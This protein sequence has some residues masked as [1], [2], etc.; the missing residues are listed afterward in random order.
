MKRFK[1]SLTKNPVF[2]SVTGLLNKTWNGT[3]VSGRAATEDQLKAAI[4]NLPADVNTITT[5]AG[6]GGIDVTDAGTGGNHDYTVKPGSQLTVGSTEQGSTDNPIF[7]DGQTGYLDGLSNTTWDTTPPQGGGP[8][9]N[10]I[11]GRA[12][13]EDQLAAAIASLPADVNT[14]TT[15]TAGNSIKV[16]DNGT[17]GNH[18]Y[19][20]DNTIKYKNVENHGFS[21]YDVGGEK[22]VMNVQAPVE[23]VKMEDGG[24]D[25]DSSA[26]F[27]TYT[28]KYTVHVPELEAGN[29]V[30]FTN[31][32]DG[33][34]GTSAA[35][36]TKIVV[37][38]NNTVTTLA[39][40]SGSSNVTVTDNGTDGNHA[41]VI[42]VDEGE[43]VEVVSD[44]TNIVVTVETV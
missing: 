3:P 28:G 24:T 7:I 19:T 39:A 1:L 25:Y 31:T 36:I 6:A 13:T 17:A 9:N 14:I 18:A 43:E 42:A 22:Y 33:E 11:S 23:Y 16:T 38:A 30:T 44:D 20:V 29:N 12:A 21:L 34:E 15:L 32:W 8:P 2:E 37:S 5:V 4:D 35:A 41:Y 40:A 27:Y 26:G 10:P